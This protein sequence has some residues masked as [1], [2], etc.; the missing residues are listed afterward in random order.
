M[1]GWLQGFLVWT[2]FTV[3]TQG[4]RWDSNH[5]E[6]GLSACGTKQKRIPRGEDDGTLS[7]ELQA[8]PRGAHDPR[9]GSV[10]LQE[11][12]EISLLGGL[13]CGEIL[14]RKAIE[15]I[16]CCRKDDGN[17][18]HNYKY[19]YIV[20]QATE[21]SKR[22]YEKMGFVRVG[23]V[24][25]YR[26]AGHCSQKNS[27]QTTG[28]ITAATATGTKDGTGPASA[29]T[30][31]ES[32]L[33]GYCHW[34]YTN[35]SSKSLDAHGGPSVMMCLR[36][37]D[38]DTATTTVNNNNNNTGHTI[39]EWLRPHIVFEKPVIRASGKVSGN[40]PCGRNGE[41]PSPS[42]RSLQNTQPQQAAAQGGVYSACQ[43]TPLRRTSNR[44][45]RGRNKALEN[46]D[47]VLF[48]PTKSALLSRQTSAK[49]PSN[50]RRKKGAKQLLASPNPQS[51]LATT[52]RNHHSQS[53]GLDER[54]VVVP[55]PSSECELLGSSSSSSSRAA[56][57]AKETND[58]Y[59]TTKPKASPTIVI[60]GEGSSSPIGTPAAV[61]AA[62]I[63]VQ[64]DT[65]VRTDKNNNVNNRSLNRN[66]SHPSSANRKQTVPIETNGAASGSMESS[67]ARARNNKHRGAKPTR[68]AGGITPE[69]P[70]REH[71]RSPTPVAPTKRS[72]RAAAATID[73]AK[74]SKQTTTPGSTD[75]FC[76]KVVVRRDIQAILDES[77]QCEGKDNNNN[78]NNDCDETNPKNVGLHYNHGSMIDHSY[79][80][81]FYFVMDS[82]EATDSLTIV[83]MFNDGVFERPDTDSNNKCKSKKAKCSG[84]SDATSCT[85][86]RF[87]G[88]PKFQCHVLENDTNWIRGVPSMDYTVVA[89]AVAVFDTPLVAR[90]AWAI[91]S[92]KVSPK[93]PGV[94]PGAKA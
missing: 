82:D 92:S 8:L 81:C 72:R 73:R 83:P 49:P 16:R 90:E 43:S 25:R 75:R 74:L 9:D 21:G 62:V 68:R 50:K 34:T 23:A 55:S 29:T 12:A 84:G 10:V 3:W 5:P 4:F 32:S 91:G 1:G 26:W 67:P 13:G 88:R 58:N 22:F 14:L 37:R 64:L 41:Y 40:T 45:K 44:S 51:P 85:N 18:K 71:P 61:A 59:N 47:Y 27:S 48:G 78:N 20:L 89:D 31:R 28:A 35:E 42:S 56:N 65:T 70:K 54:A 80:Y 33:N 53:P 24:C 15:D 52:T 39:S 2:N 86:E 76:N 79:E 94:A 30:V 57:K 87:L 60:P 6:C 63:C 77:H 19:K 11:V 46:S 93:A 69:G 38:N 17:D 36:L 66:S 7:D